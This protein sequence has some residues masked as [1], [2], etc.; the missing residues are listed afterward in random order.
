MSFVRDR[1]WDIVTAAEATT[2]S[3]D[4]DNMGPRVQNHDPQIAWSDLR[5][6]HRFIPYL[7]GNNMKQ[8]IAHG[9]PVIFFPQSIDTY[10]YA[11][12]PA[13]TLLILGYWPG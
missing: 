11:N 12:I 10:G 6:I 1:S 4:K 3:V 8:L 7:M 2:L 5:G 13:S 9:F